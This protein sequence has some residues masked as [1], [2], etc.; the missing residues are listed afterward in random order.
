MQEGDAVRYLKRCH[1]LN[2]FTAIN[3]FGISRSMAPN[4]KNFADI[5]LTS[6]FS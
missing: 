2:I 6:R 1:T 5:A 4:S 3:Q